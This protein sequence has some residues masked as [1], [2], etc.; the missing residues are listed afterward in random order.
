MSYWI[1]L[2][3]WSTCG[4]C[5]QL[6]LSQ[7]VNSSPNL[8]QSRDARNGDTDLDR[9]P[10][11]WELEHFGNLDQGPGDDP[12]D[13]GIPNLAEH[14]LAIDPNV[15][16]T[17]PGNA[18]NRP[19][20]IT[21]T[22]SS[23][24]VRRCG[25]AVLVEASD[26]EN[27][28]VRFAVDDTSICADHNCSDPPE[29]YTDPARPLASYYW[30]P[31]EAR[32]AESHTVTFYACDDRDAC[33]DPYEVPAQTRQET[34]GTVS[35]HNAEEITF[36]PNLSQPD[37]LV[38][39]GE[40]QTLTIE[41]INTYWYPPDNEDV[42]L[43]VEVLNLTSGSDLPCVGKR[44]TPDGKRFRVTWAPNHRRGGVTYTVNLV[45]CF[46]NVP[47]TDPSDWFT[48]SV[49]VE[50][51]P[52]ISY[53][54]NYITVRGGE[55]LEFE[56]RA[57]DYD[58]GP[59]NFDLPREEP[60]G[61]KFNTN[62]GQF[63]WQTNPENEGRYHRLTLRT[64][65]DS[66]TVDTTILVGVL[67]AD[68]NLVINPHMEY[69][70]DGDNQPDGWQ[71]LS[72][73]VEGGFIMSW[74]GPDGGPKFLKAER[75][76]DATAEPNWL[77]WAQDV[78]LSSSADQQLPQGAIYEFTCT[79][80]V[81]DVRLNLDDTGTAIGAHG[82]GAMMVF[83]S[84]SGEAI[85][86]AYVVDL[87]SHDAAFDGASWSD[88]DGC[89]HA[90]GACHAGIRTFRSHVKPPQQTR[91]AQIRSHSRAHG[92]VYLNYASLRPVA[93][94]PDVP[95][96][97]KSGTIALLN[98][99]ASQPIFLIGYASRMPVDYDDRL[100]TF[101]ELRKLGF[102]AAGF[103]SYRLEE[104]LASG[105]YAIGLVGADPYS[106]GEDDICFQS[107][108]EEYEGLSRNLSAAHALADA[109][110]SGLDVV[111]LE[112]PDE[113]NYRVEST[114]APPAL[115]ELNYLATRTK[116]IIDRPYMLNLMPRDW[117][118][119]LD[120]PHATLIDVASFTANCPTAYTTHPN[121]CSNSSREASLGRVGERARRWLQYSA[122]L[123]G[124]QAKPVLG[125]ALGVYWWAYW[126]TDEPRWHLHEFV[127]FHLQR[128]QVYNQIV[129][130]ACGI[131]F[132]GISHTQ[133][134][135]IY[136]RHHWDQITEITGELSA[137]YDVY[138]L[139]TFHDTWE[140]THSLE[141]MLK[142]YNGK[143]YLIATNPREH[144]LGGVTITLTHVD[145]INSVT[146]LFENEETIK[147]YPMV[148]PFDG[149]IDAT[150]AAQ[151]RKRGITRLG[152]KRAVPVNP[153]GIS[154]TDRFMDYTV[155]VYEI[156][157]G[158]PLEDSDQDSLP[159][160]WELRHF[161]NLKQDANDDPD[162]DGLVNLAEM[163]HNTVPY[164]PDSDGDGISDG[165]EVNTIGSDP[166]K[167]DTDGDRIAD[168]EDNCP[169]AYNFRQ[170]DSDGDS[171]GDACD[172]CPGNLLSIPVNNEGCSDCDGNGVR[173]SC[174]IIDGLLSDYNTN[175]IADAC[176][177]PGDL[178]GDIVVDSSDY[179]VFSDCLSPPCPNPPC[180]PPQYTNPRC[181]LADFDADADVDLCDFTVFQRLLGESGK[182][183]KRPR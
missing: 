131:R 149:V 156:E 70:D 65:A 176:D 20:T 19:P 9:L 35:I 69:D 92:K 81:Q 46:A 148:T 142:T 62:N 82:M 146:A 139:L 133:L 102:N 50:D 45:P 77:G 106:H 177:Q 155:H 174:D 54:Q 115:R 72:E 74:V 4:A 58:G 116:Q 66:H 129:N 101:D 117:G 87:I 14:M 114:G 141:A 173:D 16:N 23:T 125:Y 97:K 29:F 163:H 78:Y 161:G 32:G 113:S 51:R 22:T 42:H 110:S 57:D 181:V 73:N 130:G 160:H 178:N 55:I 7:S 135:D 153:D 21:T 1:A 182:S 49:L 126:D 39:L 63:F 140:S 44:N 100:M 25:W 27:D 145:R 138:A 59:V 18:C 79:Y 31:S 134:Q 143:I 88:A 98:N 30:M 151:V 41:N 33:A 83:Y 8:Q 118:P 13:D 34:P 165:Y 90:T 172:V 111:L 147:P 68:G 89:Y 84:A 157:H 60:E 150:D 86:S 170:E 38:T 26:P 180:D 11:Y 71:K 5:G 123:N 85:D 96:F 28:T 137:L 53:P 136:Y 17:G 167:R 64:H 120:E 168:P 12:D 2:T 154:F 94:N 144:V 15:G 162:G 36:S 95:S 93:Q 124:G 3:V 158:I 112:G 80:A 61:S 179:A 105:L 47:S 121:A 128:F 109:T 132:Y 171:V 43:K 107:G 103:L 104:H 37:N 108:I 166:T 56:V 75:T 99:K 67:P 40:G 152:W 91:Y 119:Q 127:P 175:G 183:A 6:S 52:L 122:E 48:F 24:W 10:D 159:D 164:D 76:A 169:V